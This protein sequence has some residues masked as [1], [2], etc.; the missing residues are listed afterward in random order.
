[1]SLVDEN[2][3]GMVALIGRLLH[4]L[5]TVKDGKKGKKPDTF[6]SDLGNRD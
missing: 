4:T 2:A 6:A 5:L 3:G 1:M